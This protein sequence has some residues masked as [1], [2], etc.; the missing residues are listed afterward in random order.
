MGSLV[1]LK[2]HYETRLSEEYMGVYNIYVCF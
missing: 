1:K 2:I